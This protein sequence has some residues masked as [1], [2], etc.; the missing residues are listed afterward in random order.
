MEVVRDR[1]F[2][3][4]RTTSDLLREVGRKNHHAGTGD[5]NA[6]QYGQWR[7]YKKPDFILL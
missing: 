6:L 2:F 4:E 7:R 5:P 1:R 3:K